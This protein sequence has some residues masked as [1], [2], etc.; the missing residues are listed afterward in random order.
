[1][2]KDVQLPKLNAI[3]AKQIMKSLEENKNVNKK[4]LMD[5]VAE[6]ITKVLI[7]HGLNN[8]E[9]SYV[10]LN[11]QRHLLELEKNKAS[12]NKM[13]L[14]VEQL[15]LDVLSFIMSVHAKMYREGVDS[16]GKPKR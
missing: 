11:V 9:C 13:N 15:D 8:S 6:D 4:Q 2:S 5:E 3:Q 12:L 1:M 14:T 16:R 7:L 10:L